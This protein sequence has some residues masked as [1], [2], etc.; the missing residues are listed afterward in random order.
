MMAKCVSV[1]NTPCNCRLRYAFKYRANVFL[2]F[3]TFGPTT[4]AQYPAFGLFAK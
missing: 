2:N 4:N 1:V 3:S